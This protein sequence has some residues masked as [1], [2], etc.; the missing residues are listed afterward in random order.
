MH[1]E[2]KFCGLTRP[3]DAACA[4]SLGASYVGA[5]FAGGPRHI[6]AERA[7]EVFAAAGTDVQRVGVF[8]NAAMRDIVAAARTAK[9]EVIQLHSDVTA[10]EVDKVRRETGCQVW[11]VLRVANG[12]LPSAA[13]DLI[14]TADA[15]LLDAR[16][17][18]Q[19]GGT[20]VQISWDVVADSLST[21]RGHRAVILAGGL[22]PENVRRAISVLH[23][24]VVDVSSGVESSPG[25]KD[26]ARMRAF[27]EAVWV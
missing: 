26:H 14:A 18:G 10:R 16:V 15:V 6:T 9:L 19:L 25:I 4:A 7:S 22:K 23:P 2:I 8:A 12:E 24:D 1:P 27:S 13:A 11:G 20:G 5:I 3:E 17:D 21:L